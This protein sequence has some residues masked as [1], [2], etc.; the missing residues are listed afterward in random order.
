MVPFGLTR[1]G[2][3][4]CRHPLSFPRLHSAPSCPAALPRDPGH[5]SAVYGKSTCSWLHLCKHCSVR[6]DFFLRTLPLPCNSATPSS[7]CPLAVTLLLGGTA[8]CLSLTAAQALHSRL[9]FPRSPYTVGRDPRPGTASQLLRS[10]RAF[11]PVRAALSG[12]CAPAAG[13]AAP[14]GPGRRRCRGGGE[15]GVLRHVVFPAIIS[16]RKKRRGKWGLG[17]F[18]WAVPQGSAPSPSS[19]AWERGGGRQS[20]GWTAAGG[21][22]HVADRRVLPGGGCSPLWGHLPPPSAASLSGFLP[23]CPPPKGRPQPPV[24]GEE[25][26]GPTNCAGQTERERFH[27]QAVP[28]DAPH[29]GIRSDT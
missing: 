23:P 9:F 15:S 10:L 11:L 27:P 25:Q 16:S 13:G 28:T 4:G 20:P 22:L 6:S 12:L 29:K 7:L 19:D 18:S 1:P 2:R 3:G 17:S 14:R 8:C 24:P 26:A 21:C 5:L